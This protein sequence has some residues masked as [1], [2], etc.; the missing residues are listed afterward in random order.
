MGGFGSGRYG[1][2]PT[3]EACA[4]LVLQTTTFIRAGL[5]FGVK[6]TATLTFTCDGESFPVTVSIDTTDSHFPFLWFSHARRSDPPLMEEYQVA[7]LTTPQRYGGVRW[8]FQCPRTGRR[9]VKLFLPLG[10]HRFWSR[11]G[12]GLGYAVAREELIRS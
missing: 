9:A 3:S 10:G 5:R 8:W 6:G 12:Y 1:G 2:Q 7:L 4:S 11:R